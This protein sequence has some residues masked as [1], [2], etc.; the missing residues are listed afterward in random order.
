MFGRGWHVRLSRSLRCR[1]DEFWVQPQEKS[2]Q[3]ARPHQHYQQKY[4]HGRQQHRH[5]HRAQCC[6]N[7]RESNH[8]PESYCCECAAGRK[9]LRS[10]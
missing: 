8:D 5:H 7:Y 2:E 10:A 4:N 9:S 6:G 3:Q 1:S